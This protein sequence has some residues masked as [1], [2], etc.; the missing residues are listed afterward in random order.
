MTSVLRAHPERI[1]IALAAIAWLSMFAEA[2]A[3]R[4]LSCCGP[5]PSTARDFASWIAMAGAMML[6]TT[7]YAV[8][9]VA[10]RSYYN[11][12]LRAVFGYIVGYLCCWLMTGAVFSFLRK[13]PVAHD[14]RTA[15][16]LF[17]LAGAW[18]MLPIRS[19]W[20]ARCHRQIPLSPS[21]LRAD[22][23][24][25]RQGIVHGIPCIYTCWLPMFACA[26]TGHDLLVMT[27]GT[28]LALA[29]KRMYRLNRKPLVI[30]TLALAAWVTLRSFFM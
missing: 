2:A 21:G 7:V 14:L 25:A 1:V 29:E 16:G 18:V 6:P 20:F 3:A 10:M 23:D 12:R 5:H 15:A 19:Q 17:L 22:L 26:I 4:R 27:G 24:T 9:D 8:R 13:S 11:R 28:I 30:G